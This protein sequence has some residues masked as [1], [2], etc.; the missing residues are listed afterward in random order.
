MGSKTDQG[1]SLVAEAV[2]KRLEIGFHYE[3]SE[4]NFQERPAQKPFDKKDQTEEFVI[5]KVISHRGNKP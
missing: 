4:V 5:V 2:T 3:E 1:F